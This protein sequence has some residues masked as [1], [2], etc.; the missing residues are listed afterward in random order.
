M[1]SH[2]LHDPRPLTPARVG[3]VLTPTRRP[4]LLAAAERALQ[5]AASSLQRVAR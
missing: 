5:R 1:P 4:G 2:A 3:P